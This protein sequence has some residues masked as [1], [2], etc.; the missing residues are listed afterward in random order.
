MARQSK[1]L[2]LNAAMEAAR[3][4]KKAVD[5]PWSR[6]RSGDWRGVQTK[7]RTGPMNW[8]PTFWNASNASDSRACGPLTPLDSPVK[9]YGPASVRSRCSTRSRVRQA[10]QPLP[11]K[12]TSAACRSDGRDRASVAAARTRGRIVG[13]RPEGEVRRASR[14][15]SRD[16]CRIL[17]V[18][19]S[20]L[21]RE[22]ARL[23]DSKPVRHSRWRGRDR[24]DAHAHGGGRT[25]GND[26]KL[27]SLPP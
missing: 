10:P 24:G 1:L 8:S 27:P 2:A 15:R 13:N 22:A 26:R 9:R 12:H 23:T 20:A 6:E 11:R 19:A 7:R 17:A 14:V 3:A 25:A 4:G 18:A 16:D 21:S 5:S